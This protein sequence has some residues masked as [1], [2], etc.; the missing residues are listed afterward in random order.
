MKDQSIY[1]S[2]VY[3]GAS[4]LKPHTGGQQRTPVPSSSTF[5]ISFR[6]ISRVNRYANT[7]AQSNLPCEPAASLLWPPTHCAALNAAIC[8]L[9]LVRRIRL[10]GWICTNATPDPGKQSHPY[11]QV[12][13]AATLCARTHW[14]GVLGGTEST[15][16]QP[17]SFPPACQ[18]PSP[19]TAPRRK[20]T[21]SKR[22]SISWS[23][24]L[25]HN[26]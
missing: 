22:V 15:C 14:R 19:P 20:S 3:K 6:F 12:L 9:V 18:P 13:A 5:L 24:T 10:G 1:F 16:R 7:Q 25:M 4:I 26:D 2:P 11:R 21:L 23:V 8:P 17:S